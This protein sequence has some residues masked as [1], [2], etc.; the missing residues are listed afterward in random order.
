[1]PLIIAAVSGV[2]LRVT[3]RILVSIESQTGL[4][5]DS[6]CALGFGRGLGEQTVEDAHAFPF[7][8]SWYFF[9]AERILESRNVQ[10]K[11]RSSLSSLASS[12]HS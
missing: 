3:D 12:M 11:M 4:T 1:M 8:A 5:Q 2:F 10:R 7:W 6:S 9:R